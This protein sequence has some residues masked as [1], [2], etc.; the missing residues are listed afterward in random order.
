MAGV[1]SVAGAV[2]L[3]GKGGV[4]K[5]TCALA[6]GRALAT[7]GPV[8]VMSL[9]PA[10][11]LGDLAGVRVGHDPVDLGP[12]LCAAEPDLEALCAARSRAAVELIEQR[13][14]HIEAFNL[15]SL[16]ALLQYA[17]GLLEQAAL[18]AV[19]AVIMGGRFWSTLVLDMPPTGLA[20]RIL[21]MPGLQLEWTQVLGKLRRRILDR[22]SIIAHVGGTAGVSTDPG[23]DPVMCELESER[24]SLARVQD[25][26]VHRTRHLLVVNPELLAITEAGRMREV[27]RRIGTD[28]S[29]IVVNRAA[30]GEGTVTDETG[31]LAGLSRVT[32]AP[33]E[34]ACEP[35]GLDRV[36]SLLAGRL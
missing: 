23:A 13:Y 17:P 32:I 11:N 8:L 26:F 2:S 25:L 5:T 24:A 30:S 3:L 28:A 1:T 4:G 7:A 9:D 10:H 33:L 21:A 34:D 35:S 14:H 31:S 27:L 16:P 22:R 29:L 15:G 19:D 36:G 20:S 6:L 12:G 18:D